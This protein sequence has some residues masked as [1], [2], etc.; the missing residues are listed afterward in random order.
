M[1]R[2]TPFLIRAAVVVII[3]IAVLSLLATFVPQRQPAE[4]YTTRYPAFAAGLIVFF[5]FNDFFRSAVFLILT[6]LFFVDLALCSLIRLVT[7]ISTR[8]PKRFGPDVIHLGLLLVIMAGVFSFAAR[9]EFSFS[10]KPGDTRNFP[11]GYR[12]SLVS[13]EFKRYPDGRPADW[14]SRVRVTRAGRTTEEAIEVNHPLTLGG[15]TLYQ[16]SYQEFASVQLSGDAGTIE[17]MQHESFSTADGTFA[18]L[19]PGSS[20]GS[21]VFGRLSTAGAIMDYAAVENGGTVGSMSLK[22]VFTYYITGLQAVRDPASWLV[23]VALVI[24]A[25]GL[26]LTMLQK[27]REAA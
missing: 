2:L 16:S 12:V 8:A 10:M 26:L 3:L 6:G 25:A 27:R 22:Q 7:R 24:S 4:F 13:F 14:I 5:S 18:F 17:V 1:S 20:P 19:R 15:V 11:G 23:I 21:A 9:E